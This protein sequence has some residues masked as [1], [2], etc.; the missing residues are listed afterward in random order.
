MPQ[1][2]PATIFSIL[3]KNKFLSEKTVFTNLV[4]QLENKSKIYSQCKFL[5]T[6]IDGSIIDG[7]SDLIIV[8][9]NKGVLFLEVKGGIVGYKAK[10]QQWLSLRRDENKTYKIKDPLNQA[11]KAMFAIRDL[12][13]EQYPELEKLF[14]N[15][16]YAACLPDTPRP[17]DPRPFGPDKP[18]ELFFFREDLMSLKENIYRVLDWHKGERIFNDLSLDFQKKIHSLIVGRDMPVKIPLKKSIEIENEEMIFSEEQKFLLKTLP[19]LNYVAVKGGAGTGKT[20]VAIELIRLLATQKKIL[21]LC[22]NKPLARHVRYSLKGTE[23]EIHIHNCHQWVNSL[24]RRYGLPKSNFIDI[25]KEIEDLVAQVDNE[26][27]KY[28][29][30]IIDE[31]QDFNDEWLINIE[32][33]LRKSGKFYVFYDEQQSIFDKNPQYFLQERFSHLELEEN[34]RNTKQIFD[35]F[36]QFNFQENFSS[37][38]PMGTPPEFITVKNYQQQFKWIA[39]KINN[40]HQHEGIPLRD[41]GVLLYDGLKQTNEKNLSKVIPDLTKAELCSAEYVQPNQIMFDTINRIKG[42]EIPIMFLTNFVTPLENQKLYVGLSRSKHR[43]YIV[44]L[45]S[46]IIELKKTIGLM[47]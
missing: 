43:I 11:R 39:D 9:P 15:F 2:F 30:I 40:L 31:A 46:K 26:K 42:L 38:G 18:Q 12:L 22:F 8:I 20:L 4:E 32:H 27:F 35:I 47:S 1:Y 36:R 19:N 45:E 7:E 16:A 37:K 21:F 3:E 41:M 44:G 29:V 10:E 33:M 5:K 28:D 25:D 13:L 14:F 23:G 17:L 6:N 34:F 24:M